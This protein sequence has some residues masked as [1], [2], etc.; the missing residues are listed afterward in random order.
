[1]T[2]KIRLKSALAVF[3]VPAGLFVATATD[4]QAQTTNCTSYV[5]GNTITTN[6]QGS[7]SPGFTDYP[8]L[9]ARGIDVGKAMRDAEALRTQRLQNQ[10]LQQ[11]LQ[12]QQLQL[13]I[14]QRQQQQIQELRN[15][16]LPAPQPRAALTNSEQQATVAA[17]QQALTSLGYDCGP[18][19]GIAGPQTRAAIRAFQA[20]HDLAV[21]GE[22]T[23][24][25]EFDLYA[26][27]LRQQQ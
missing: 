27:R 22:A 11:Q 14:L 2:H 16:R 21:T 8:A 7:P 15:R 13:Q 5:L 4:A 9:R 19:N 3:L 10:L 12:Q 26:Q 6:C 18:S 24:S 25:L 23:A 17:V 1:M 20:D